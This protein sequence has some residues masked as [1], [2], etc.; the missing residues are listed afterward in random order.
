EFSI[1]NELAVV[2]FNNATGQLGQTTIVGLPHMPTNVLFSTDGSKI[3]TT[4]YEYRNCESQYFLYQQSIEGNEITAPWLINDEY[5][6]GMTRAIDNRIYLYGRGTELDGFGNFKRGLHVINFP[7]QPKAA[8]LFEKRKYQTEYVFDF[9]MIMNDYVKEEKAIQLPQLS[10]PEKFTLCNKPVVVEAPA[11]YDRYVWSNGMEGRKISVSQAGQLSVLAYKNGSH[12]A[13]FGVTSI[14]LTDNNTINL[15]ADTSV[16]LNAGFRL[17]VSNNF[18]EVRWS[19]GTTG[20]DYIVNTNEPYNKTIHVW[21]TNA[22]GCYTSDTICVTVVE[23]PKIELGN[24]T[25]LCKGQKL[26]LIPDIMAY[27]TPPGFYKWSVPSY[28]NFIDVTESGTYWCRAEK[29]GCLNSDTIRVTF[30]DKAAIFLGNDTSL[31]VGDSVIIKPATYK[32]TMLWNGEPG[33]NAIMV[34]QTSTIIAG[35]PMPGCNLTDTIAV[36]FKPIPTINL[37]L[38]TVYCKGKGVILDPKLSGARVLWNN[39]WYLPNLYVNYPTNLSVQVWQEGCYAEKNIHITEL[40]LP[41]IDI[42]DD[43]LVCDSLS[44]LL[45]ANSSTALSYL[46]NN[47]Q[48]TRELLVYNTGNYIV[49]VKDINGCENAD[50]VTITF[51]NT[52]KVNLGKDSS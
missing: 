42:G 13:A 28:N 38:D 16:C 20:N 7:N 37:P 6:T 33:A 44:T 22:D 17:S 3:Y 26:A 1:K 5:I 12:L 43:R 30:L 32:G 18:K 4:S 21:A 36:V 47:G 41:A 51:N 8:C 15:P 46:W 50:T 40:P 14:E 9:P 35:L 48:T 27:F 23:P 10:L 31:C 39:M 52:P 11:G 29:N 24:D 25:T 45:K 19:D 49:Y 2:N 34:K